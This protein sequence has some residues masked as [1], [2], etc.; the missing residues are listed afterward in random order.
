ML[1]MPTP[2]QSPI[3]PRITTRIV[4]Q[5]VLPVFE[6]QLGKIVRTVIRKA[7]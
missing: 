7:A 1:I 4:S 3:A 6:Q 5:A 2:A